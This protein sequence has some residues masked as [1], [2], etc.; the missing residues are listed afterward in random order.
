MHIKKEGGY[1]F[2]IHP[3]FVYINITE[4]IDLLYYLVR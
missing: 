3:P 4:V 1:L 2:D